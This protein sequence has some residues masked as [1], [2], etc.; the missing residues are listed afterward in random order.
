MKM[1]NVV[2]KQVWSTSSV[3]STWKDSLC[4]KCLLVQSRII[5]AAAKVKL[6]PP[7]W[8]HHYPPA[9]KKW[10]SFVTWK[11]YRRVKAATESILN[12]K[13][14]QNKNCKVRVTMAHW[15]QT[16]TARFQVQC[17]VPVCRSPGKQKLS[18]AVALAFW[19]LD[20]EWNAVRQLWI[21]RSKR[22]KIY[23][24]SLER[25]VTLCFNPKA[26]FE[27]SI[28]SLS[29]EAFITSRTTTNPNTLAR[30]F[31]CCH[32]YPASCQNLQLFSSWQPLL[33]SC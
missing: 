23:L 29:P 18:A 14:S 22:S 27:S 8:S 24:P 30:L 2:D 32:L 15:D 7:L 6:H 12:L 26:S 33:G 4:S 16:T 31:Q 3:Y 21:K 25:R 28:S 11:N 9:H 10:I 17:L 19:F 1:S 13:A 20:I 5:Y